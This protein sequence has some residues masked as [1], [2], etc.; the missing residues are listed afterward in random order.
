MGM[1][2][3]SQH[4]IRTQERRVLAESLEEKFKRATERHN[5]LHGTIL[6]RYPELEDTKELR[7]LIDDR[8][9]WRAEIDRLEAEYFNKCF[10]RLITSRLYGYINH[11]E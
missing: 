8:A 10:G 1:V 7:D 3:N 11:V 2:A 6:A 4:A 9:M 5:I